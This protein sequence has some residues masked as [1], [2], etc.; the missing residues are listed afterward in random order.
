M[1]SGMNSSTTQLLGAVGLGAGEAGVVSDQRD[2][3][4]R[5]AEVLH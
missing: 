1:S 3:R 2:R 5:Q 4:S